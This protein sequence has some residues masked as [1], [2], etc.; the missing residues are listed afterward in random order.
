MEFYLKITKALSIY[1]PHLLSS[2]WKHPIED[3]S[4]NFSFTN[5]HDILGVYLFM[6]QL[7]FLH[8]LPVWD[9]WALW[10]YP[11]WNEIVQKDT[12]LSFFPF[13]CWL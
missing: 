7:C 10:N 1:I 8:K 3:N 9:E 12:L 6:E 13:K 5:V 2:F 4:F 11:V